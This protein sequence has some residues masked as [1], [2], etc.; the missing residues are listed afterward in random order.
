M[1]G[2]R[3]ELDG[4]RVAGAVG[5]ALQPGVG[6]EG[7]RVDLVDGSN[8]RRTPAQWWQ[9]ASPSPDACC[10]LDPRLAWVNTR[11]YAVDG[12]ASSEYVAASSCRPLILVNYCRDETSS[13]TAGLCASVP[14]LDAWEGGK[15]GGARHQ[16][17]ED[18][19]YRQGRHQGARPGSNE[20][21]RTGSRRQALGTAPS[22]WRAAPHGSESERSTARTYGSGPASAAALRRR[23]APTISAAPAVHKRGLKHGKCMFCVPQ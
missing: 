6:Q 18:G 17:L 19:A 9:T 10:A 1:L 4:R 13:V 16:D 2:V 22:H 20:G 5:L 12:G 11:V 8:Q 23:P 15:V 7:R 21:M 3:Q 14:G